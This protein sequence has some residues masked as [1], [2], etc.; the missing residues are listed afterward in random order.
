MS[1]YHFPGL[2]PHGDRHALNALP[3]RG[4]RLELVMPGVERQ[5]P[6]DLP[7]PGTQG[8]AGIDQPDK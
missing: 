5:H 2:Y 1:E 6:Q 3:R 7:G 4:S 8:N